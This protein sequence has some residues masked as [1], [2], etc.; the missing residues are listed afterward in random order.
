MYLRYLYY[1]RRLNERDLSYDESFFFLY[2][3][4]FF[5]GN[6]WNKVCAQV[7]NNDDDDTP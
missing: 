6:I 7:M 3:G 1:L 5:S 4:M 2:S